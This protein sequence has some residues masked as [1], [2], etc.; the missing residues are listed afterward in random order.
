M[1]PDDAGERVREAAREADDDR[2]PVVR[3][4]DAV[5]DVLLR[6]NY[7]QRQRVIFAITAIFGEPK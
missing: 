7:A 3:G 4:V 2:E 6:L 5:C 1:S